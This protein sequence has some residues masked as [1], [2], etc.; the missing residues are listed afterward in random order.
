MKQWKHGSKWGWIAFILTMGVVA[1]TLIVVSLY[2]SNRLREFRSDLFMLTNDSS[3]CIAEGPEGLIRVDRANWPALY[4]L[5][6]KSKGA[7]VL[8]EPAAEESLT[9]SFACNDAGWTL[10]VDKIS[11]EVLRIVMDG[12]RSYVVYLENKRTY[13]QFVKAA[14]IDSFNVPNKKMK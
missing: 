6:E 7:L 13:E 8:D 10:T 3:S 4:A 14:S 11:E 5:V 12:K 2:E 9:F 1:V